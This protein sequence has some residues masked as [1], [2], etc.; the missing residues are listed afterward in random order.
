[1][2]FLLILLIAVLAVIVISSVSSRR[3]QKR[4]E[5]YSGLAKEEFVEHFSLQGIPRPISETVYDTFKKKVRSQNFR[6]SPEMSIEGVFEQLEED[7]DDDA[8]HILK[9][10]GI[11]EPSEEILERWEGHALETLSD[12]VVWTDWVR[13]QQNSPLVTHERSYDA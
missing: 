9:V 10:L 6:P 8:H 2:A 3:W 5:G 11:P 4:L 7:T 13:R 12:L 1:M